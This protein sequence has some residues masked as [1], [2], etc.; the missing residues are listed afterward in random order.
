[1][2]DNIPLIIAMAERCEE[3][4]RASDNP[5]LDQPTSL[6]ARHLEW[7][8]KQIGKH[9]GEWP[10]TKTHRWIGFI[11]GAMIANRMIDLA[12]AKSM[13]DQTKNRHGEADEDLLDHLDPGKPFKL[14][15]GGQG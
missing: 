1:M 6:Q 2:S 5:G 14:E 8:C 3:M 11:Q 15:I 7:M 12:G 13:F 10:A 9:A 4:I